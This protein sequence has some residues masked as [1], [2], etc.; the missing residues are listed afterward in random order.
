MVFI[1][2]TLDGAQRWVNVNEIAALEDEGDGTIVYLKGNGSVHIAC[3]QG[4]DDVMAMI[5]REE[6]G[7]SVPV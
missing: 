2:L 4:I 7:D 5:F 1:C 3:D 6:E